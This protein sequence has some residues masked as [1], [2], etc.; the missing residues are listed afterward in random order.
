M[1]GRIFFIGVLICSFNICDATAG[2]LSQAL[3]KP[4]LKWKCCKQDEDCM[5]TSV[6]TCIDTGCTPRCGS[7]TG[8]ELIACNK[9][10]GKEYYE[11]LKQEVKDYCRQI[12]CAY[13]Y[14]PGPEKEESMIPDSPG[15]REPTEE[16]KREAQ[17]RHG[18]QAVCE[19]SKCVLN[20]RLRHANASKK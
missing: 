14:D 17:K 10:H 7:L 5:V 16:E 4:W 8:G 3:K 2:G 20:P 13:C 15:G 6:P 19:K 1:T 12:N 11:I 18:P 9:I